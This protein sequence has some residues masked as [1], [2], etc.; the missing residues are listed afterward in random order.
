MKASGD[1]GLPKLFAKAEDRAARRNDILDAAQ[2]EEWT[3]WCQAAG[4]R[5]VGQ[6][7]GW[8]FDGQGLQQPDPWWGN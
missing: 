7:L 2:R 6:N 4:T 3:K 1:G 8:N 5:I